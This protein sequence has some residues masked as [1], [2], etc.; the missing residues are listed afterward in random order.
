MI[1]STIVI[2]E[3]EYWFYQFLLTSELNK[4]QIPYPA[5]FSGTYLGKKNS[6]IRLLFDE[7]WPIDQLEYNYWYLENT[8][9]YSWPSPIRDRICIYPSARYYELDDTTSEDSENV[10]LLKDDDIR[11]LDKLLLYKTNQEVDID[12]IDSTG[13]TTI[14]S[15]MMYTYL[16]LELNG[17]YDNF[18][19]DNIISENKLLD[20]LYEIFIVERIFNQISDKGT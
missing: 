5:S 15:N 17:E 3:L 6:F 2:P 10:F 7:N 18:D 11:M 9:K 19:L 13:L 20:T 12:D 4:H 8:N 14:L 16:N 1:N